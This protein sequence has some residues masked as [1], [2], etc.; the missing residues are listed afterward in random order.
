[1]DEL[2]SVIITTYERPQFI[3]RCINSVLSQSY[4]NI[5]IILIDDGSS[6]TYPRFNSK[7]IRYFKN[8]KN[9][10][11]AYSRNLGIKKAKGELIFILD[12]DIL[13]TKRYIERLVRTLKEYKKENIVGVGGRLLYPQRPDKGIIKNKPLFEISKLTGDIIL[14][15]SVNTKKPVVVPTLHS[16]SVFLKE[17]FDKVKYEE[18]LYRGNYTYVEPDFCFRIRKLGYKLMFEPRAIAY[19]YQ[20]KEGGCRNMSNFLYNYSTVRNA[21]FFIWRFYKIKILYMW[22]LFILKRLLKNEL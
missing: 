20:L 8:K 14:R 11:S 4:K 16:C 1:M 9:K 13:L 15:A 17:V 22:P 18:K 19:H 6:K 7:K 2:V 21:F 3:N 5:E 10:G 12:D